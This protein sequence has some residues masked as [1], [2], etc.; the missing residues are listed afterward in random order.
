MPELVEVYARQL[1]NDYS[2]LPR[3]AGLLVDAQVCVDAM[4]RQ[5]ARKKADE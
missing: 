4:N 5:R 2:D 3:S 1:L